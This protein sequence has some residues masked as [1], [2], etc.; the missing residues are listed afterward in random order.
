MQCLAG[1]NPAGAVDWQERSTLLLYDLFRE[2]L[3][4]WLA[5]LKYALRKI[6]VFASEFSHL[7]FPPCSDCRV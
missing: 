5:G 1:A 2:D 6:G 3:G 4:S 7:S